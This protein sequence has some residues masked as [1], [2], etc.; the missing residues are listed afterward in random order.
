MLDLYHLAAAFAVG[1][2]YAVFC[3]A[4]VEGLHV[5]G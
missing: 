5:E 3:F 2:G 1:V 4:V